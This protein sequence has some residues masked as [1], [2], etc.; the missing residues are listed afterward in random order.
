M[1]DELPTPPTEW[2]REQLR[3]VAE[4]LREKAYE[5]LHL[6]A[7]FER[8]AEALESATPQLETGLGDGGAPVRALF[9]SPAGDKN[10]GGTA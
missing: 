9:L 4:R 2:T 1:R 8:R 10:D 3:V 7:D 6:A 5:L